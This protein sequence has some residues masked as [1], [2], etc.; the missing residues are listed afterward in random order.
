MALGVG[1]GRGV[2]VGVAV[3]GGVGVGVIGGVGVAVGV[4]V[5]VT[6]V[7]NGSN[8]LTKTGEPVL[9]KPIFALPVTGG[10][11]DWNLKLYNVPN[12]IALAFGFCAIVS[13]LHVSA[14]PLNSKVQGASLYPAS[15]TVPSLGNPGCCGGA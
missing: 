4:G 11:V 1:V 13:V 7:A 10:A 9:K 14:S 8:T 12:R 15:P 2:G 3:G 6:S 5:G